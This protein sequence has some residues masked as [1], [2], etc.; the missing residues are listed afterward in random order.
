MGN[1]IGERGYNEGGEDNN[2]WAMEPWSYGTMELWSYG[3]TATEKFMG[4]WSYS[5]RIGYGLFDIDG[6]GGGGRKLVTRG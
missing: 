2:Y 6:R 4:L 5:D 1:E 3:A